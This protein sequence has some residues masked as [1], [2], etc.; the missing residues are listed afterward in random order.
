[1]RNLIRYL[2]IALATALIAVSALAAPTL[3]GSPI[4]PNQCDITPQV[5]LFEHIN[6]N[7]Q[8]WQGASDDANFGAAPGITNFN[9]KLSSLQT[10]DVKIRLY[11]HINYEGYYII[12]YPDTYVANLGNWG[13]W[14]DR[15]SSMD[16]VACYIGVG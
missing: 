11:E 12:V 7:G 3:A 5:W 1:M 2:S 6:E 9:D 4:G 13:N 8:M 14:N 10:F 15:V 16:V